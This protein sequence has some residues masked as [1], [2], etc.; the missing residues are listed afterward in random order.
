MHW[1]KAWLTLTIPSSPMLLHSLL[2]RYLSDSVLECEI[3][4]SAFF[5]SHFTALIEM[6]H[7]VIII[8]YRNIIYVYMY[9]WV[10]RIV[11]MSKGVG[12][13]TMHFLEYRNLSRRPRKRF[14]K[15]PPLI[16]LKKN[17]IFRKKIFLWIIR[18]LREKTTV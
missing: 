2:F 15:L 10:E 12:L 13:R 9:S 4:R 5:Y 7:C 16:W 18:M 11:K 1:H 14:L 17:R 3:P 8:A 6:Y